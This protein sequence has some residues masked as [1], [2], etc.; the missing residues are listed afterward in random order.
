MRSSRTGSILAST[1]HFH[2]LHQTLILPCSLFTAMSSKV[3][4]KHRITHIV[5][6]SPDYPS[7]GPEHL[8]V[9]VDD[10]AHENLLQHLN[11]ACQFIQ[12]AL[13]S[14]GRVL[15]HCLMGVSR[16]ATV[17]AGY[18]QLKIQNHLPRFINNWISV[19]KTQVL[20]LFCDLI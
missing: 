13:D 14:N 10:E 5:S 18:C 15:V 3:K 17:V 20:M 12:N 6:V 19:M 8:V 4:S 1:S 11:T 2:S 16:S 7:T 9:S